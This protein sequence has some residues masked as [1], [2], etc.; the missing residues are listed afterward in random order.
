MG[1]YIFQKKKILVSFLRDVSTFFENRVDK[2]VE[3]MYIYMQGIFVFWKKNLFSDKLA[4][5]CR[6]INF[7][8]IIFGCFWWIFL[9][10]KYVFYQKKKIPCM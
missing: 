9:E 7:A 8:H 1:W 3:E 5:V 4:K 2:L 6:H 10:M